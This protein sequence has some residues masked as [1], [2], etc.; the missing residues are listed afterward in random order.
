M[1]GRKIKVVKAWGGFSGGRLHN[2][3]AD[4]AYAEPAVQWVV[5]TSRKAARARYEDVRRV[6]IVIEEP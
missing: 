6:S 3:K 5:Y 1:G 4:D 2:W